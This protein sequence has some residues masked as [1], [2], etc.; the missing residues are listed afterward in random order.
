MLKMH[1][2]L[3]EGQRLTV[4]L[5]SWV[6]GYTE[7]SMVIGHPRFFLGPLKSTSLNFLIVKKLKLN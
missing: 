3:A 1:L 4:L 6:N 5:G 7:E 2:C